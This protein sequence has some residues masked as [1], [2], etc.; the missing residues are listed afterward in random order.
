MYKEKDVDSMIH[1]LLELHASMDEASS[2]DLLR[3][4]DDGFSEKVGR[5]GLSTLR[6]ISFRHSYGRDLAEARQWINAFHNTKNLLFVHQAWDLYHKIHTRLSTQLK[7]LKKIEMSHICALTAMENLRLAVPGSA[8]NIEGD[9]EVI[10]IQRFVH[11]IDVINSKQRPRKLTMIGSD[12]RRYQFLLKGKEDL[13]QDERVM[14]LF[15]LINI[16]MNNYRSSNGTTNLAI[17]R[18]SVL[19]LSSNSG[20]IGWV[21]NCDTILQLVLTYRKVKSIAV[22]VEEELIIHSLSNTHHA[23]TYTDFDKLSVMAKI[24][25]FYQI[26]HQTKG[27]DVAKM[28]WLKSKTS[29]VWVERRANFT[30]SIAMMSIVGYILGLG[31]RHLAN[32]LLDR[33]SGKVVHIDFGDCFESTQIRSKFP[34]KVPFR[35][36]RMLTSAMEVSG[37]EGTFRSTSEIVMGVLHDNRDSVQAMLEAFQYDPLVSWK[38]KGVKLMVDTIE[39]T[40]PIPLLTV[41][42]SIVLDDLSILSKPQYSE[43][44]LPEDVRSSEN[45]DTDEMDEEG[46]ATIQEHSNEIASKKLLRI[47]AKYV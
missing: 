8:S 19:P 38:G 44:S 18:Y 26:M 36:T 41:R 47:Q 43:Y 23:A 2:I 45:M 17:S 21:K 6:D 29:D 37:I 33:I 4:K 16:C 15:F 31:D 24:E 3:Q 12:G 1:K 32:L 30:K 27:N 10:R 42:E 9:G 34:E 46:Y 25:V 22:N 14:Q 20:L 28:L 7:S 11:S 5:I 35:L 13:R 40:I 39:P